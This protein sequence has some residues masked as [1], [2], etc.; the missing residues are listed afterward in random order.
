MA[1]AHQRAELDQ[2][3]RLGRSG[4]VLAD[5]EL[6]EGAPQQ[7][8]VADRV[9]RRREHESSRVGRERLEPSQ[10]AALD[11]AGQRRRIR[12]AEAARQLG[13]GQAAWQLEQR[14]RVAARL[15]DDPLAHPLVHGPHDRRLQQRAS[16]VVGQ[17]TDDQLREPVE[18]DAVAGLAHREDQRDALGQ[19]PAGDERQRLHRDAVQPLG[20][21]DDADQRRLLGHLG[22][23]AQHGQ[24]DE[25]PVRRL[26]AAHAERGAQRITL[27]IGDP[28]HA[29][30][31]WSTEL[32]QAGERELHLG[33]DA[34]RRGDPAARRA[35]DEVLEQRRLADPRLAA[36]DQD[37]T[38]ARP[39]AV[40]QP[41]QRLAL[42]APP[43]QT[44]PSIGVRHRVSRA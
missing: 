1:E 3:G 5:P 37:A 14:E 17:A 44:W 35:R 28:I 13:R 36:H 43:A 23:E 9:G 22:Q 7:G 24:P 11:A 39:D 19:E 32:M 25:E 33:L 12:Q 34:G 26:A 30:Q 4:R 20:I 40:Q 15:R 31:Q 2:P 10:E 38:L 29:V 18:L 6:L 21:V 16:V 27:R 41:V 8:R 42:A